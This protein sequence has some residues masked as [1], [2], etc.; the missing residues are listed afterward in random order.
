[1]DRTSNLLDEAMYMDLEDPFGGVVLIEDCVETNGAFILHHLIKRHL[2]PPP[3]SSPSGLLI[4][5]AFAQPFSHYDRI[6]R[7]MVAT[8]PQPPLSFYSNIFYQCCY[9]LYCYKKPPGRIRY[10][11]LF[12]LSILPMISS[13]SEFFLPN[14]GC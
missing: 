4:F 11:T 13:F 8:P 14:L 1:M 5:V 12:E 7:K 9:Y 10:Q 3:Q 2:S 6:L